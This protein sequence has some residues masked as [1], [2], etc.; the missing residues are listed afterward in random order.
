MSS[1]FPGKHARRRSAGRTLLGACSQE[2][3]RHD[4]QRKKLDCD[5]VIPRPQQCAGSYDGP[6]ELSQNQGKWGWAFTTCINHTILFS[7][8]LM[9]GALLILER[10][11]LPELASSK[12]QKLT[13]LRAQLSDANQPIQSPH[14]HT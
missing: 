9:S 1:W 11:P 12:R 8:V 5:I 10:L 2:Q 6:S 14:P 13:P 3:G 4:G 7:D